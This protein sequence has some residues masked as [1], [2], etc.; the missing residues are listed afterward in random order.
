MHT[1]SIVLSFTIDSLVGCL[2]T[3]YFLKKDL[4][5]ALNFSDKDNDYK[6]GKSKVEFQESWIPWAANY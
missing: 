3:D 6:K 1:I 4:L 5:Y 2:L